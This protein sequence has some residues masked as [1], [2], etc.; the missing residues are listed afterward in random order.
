M[1]YFSIATKNHP[2]EIW[3]GEG[4][5]SLLNNISESGTILLVGSHRAISSFEVD[6]LVSS[7]F[8]S[9]R[10]HNFYIN[11]EYPEVTFLSNQLRKFPRHTYKLI[12]AIG[13]GA[14]I[15][16]AKI[17]SVALCV[18]Q[19]SCIV[20]LLNCKLKESLPIICLPTTAGTGSEVTPFATIWDRENRIKHSLSSNLIYPKLAFVDP[21]LTYSLPE[22]VTIETSLDALNQAFESLWNINATNESVRFANEAIKNSFMGISSIQGNLGLINRNLLAKASLMAGISI[23][24]TKTSICHSISYPITSH[25]NIPHGIACAFTMLSILDL[26]IQEDLDSSPLA[27]LGIQM[28]GAHS[29]RAK[30]LE[31]MTKFQVSEYVRTRIG[32]VEDLLSLTKEMVTPGRFDNFH[33]KNFEIDEIIRK[34][35]GVA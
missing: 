29:I 30:L 25:F 20:S 1:K 12:V 10:I 4:C 35:W 22:R 24:H 26:C 34:S 33:I 15:D 14:A 7:F 13:G 16:T 17:L 5:R 2:T 32:R 31:I 6:P 11:S 27:L 28:G 23:S 21:F 18:D 8:K 19:T 9:S 3:F